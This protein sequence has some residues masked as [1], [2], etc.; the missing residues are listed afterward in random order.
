M[1]EMNI[2]YI[3]RNCESDTV[4]RKIGQNN[5]CNNCGHAMH[6]VSEKEDR[7]YICECVIVESLQRVKDN[8]AIIYENRLFEARGY[9]CYDDYMRDAF[10]GKKI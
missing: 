4:T 10:K 2:D 7:L 9:G 1:G 8:F 5:V 3:C 6:L